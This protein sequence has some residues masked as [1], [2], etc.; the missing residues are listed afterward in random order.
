MF[1]LIRVFF[2]FS[3]WDPRFIGLIRGRPGFNFMPT[4]SGSV[5]GVYLRPSSK[6]TQMH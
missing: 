1:T 6:V 4:A 5:F 3:R 2:R